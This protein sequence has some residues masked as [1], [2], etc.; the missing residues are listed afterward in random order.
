VIAAENGESLSNQAIAKRAKYSVTEKTKADEVSD[1]N[2]KRRIR[3]MSVSRHLRKAK[4]IVQNTAIG[5][6]P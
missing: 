6:F 3:S 2:Y 5:V 1:K 4:N